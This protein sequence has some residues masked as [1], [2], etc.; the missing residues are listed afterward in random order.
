MR[1][2]GLALKK[3]KRLLLD[4]VNLPYPLTE[5]WLDSMLGSHPDVFGPFAHNRTDLREVIEKVRNYLRLAWK[6][7]ALRERDW[8][9]FVAR[10]EYSRDL[11]S[12]LPGNLRNYE[13]FLSAGHEHL[14]PLADLGARLANSLPPQT[15]FDRGVVYAQRM[16][17]CEGPNCEDRFFLRGPKRERYCSDCKREARLRSKKKYWHEKGKYNRK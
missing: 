9:L 11:L 16:S 8:W 17:C 14:Q 10:Q 4:W 13:R 7:K 1:Y 15:A 3:T 12:K 2:Y 6:S 5:D